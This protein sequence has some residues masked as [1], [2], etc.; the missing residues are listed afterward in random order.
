ME[1]VLVQEILTAVKGTLIKGNAGNFVN[2]ISTDT[3]TLKEGD[4]FIPLKG[5]KYDGH[6]FLNEALNKK[7]S[8][9]IIAKKN[10]KNSLS[11][12]NNTIIIEVE[13]TLQ[14]LHDF[15]QYYRSKFNPLVIAITG[16]NG[17]TT[18]KEILGNILKQNA[19]TLVNFGNWNNQVG[20]PLTLLHLTSQ[21]RYC[22]LE[23][24]TNHL[25]EIANLSK[26]AQPNLAIITNISKTHL[27]FFGT[28][29]NVLKEKTSICK[30]LPSEGTLIL[31]AD[32]PLLSGIS[33]P[34][35]KI[36]FGIRNKLNVWATGIKE[37]IKGYNFLLHLNGCK[38]KIH[39]PLYGFFNIYNA[40]DAAACAQTISVN[41]E[42]IAKVLAN[43]T[44]LPSRMNVIHLSTDTILVDDCYNANPVSMREG[45]KSFMKLYPRKEKILVLGDMLELGEK[46]KQEHF[47][48]G[49][50][51]ASLPVNTVFLYGREIRALA[52]GIQENNSQQVFIFTDKNKLI[53]K[54]KYDLQ[55]YKAIVYKASQLIQWDEVVNALIEMD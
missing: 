29:E 7:A 31:N 39:F 2:N 21:H 25:G 50:F 41:S 24:G 34:Y 46:S 40:L 22:V 26:I 32:D 10:I 35:K 14:A 6:N 19:P 43:F 12:V 5:E 13:D 37:N 30:F 27:E 4:F 55:P 15:I 44:P 53:K 20:L 47:E 36:F 23:M 16:S 48:L 17:K 11:S 3:R 54:L 38:T 18:T 45:I 1:K 33:A 9:V 8:G 49:K 51:I 52:R 42:T 28:V